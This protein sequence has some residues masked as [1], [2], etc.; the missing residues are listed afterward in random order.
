MQPGWEE[1]GRHRSRFTHCSQGAHGKQPST[2]K[3]HDALATLPGPDVERPDVVQQVRIGENTEGRETGNRKAALG[4]GLCSFMQNQAPWC[5]RGSHLPPM[6][7][8]SL[9][10]AT[11]PRN[12]SRFHQKDMSVKDWMALSTVPT[13]AIH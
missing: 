13:T 3:E 6:A 10:E 7:G 5:P 9:L 1:T 2:S 12:G 8:L 11:T 4:Y